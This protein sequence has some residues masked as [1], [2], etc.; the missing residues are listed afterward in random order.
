MTEAGRQGT[1]VV[2]FTLTELIV[3]M[4]MAVT[5]M[6]V[7]VSVMAVGSDGYG[8][9]NRR[10]NANVE[11]R[12]ALT[13]LTDDVAGILFDD[14]FVLKTGDGTWPSGELSFLALKPRGAQD[15]S[16]A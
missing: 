10:V 3:S 13:T 15:A 2:G 14:N 7:V 8:Q 9:A 12:A 6:L 5:L 4:G 11:A 16:K 1:R